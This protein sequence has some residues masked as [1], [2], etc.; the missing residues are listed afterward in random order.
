MFQDNQRDDMTRLKLAICIPVYDKPEAMFMQS[1]LAAIR[2][3]PQANLTN[4]HDEKYHADVQTF[5][6][7]SSNL[8]QNRH[9]LAAEAV[10][11]GADYMLFADADH[12]FPED[13]IARLW[14]R[15]KQ[16]I[17]CNY[18]RRCTPTA[19]TAAQDVTSADEEDYKN[20]VYTSPEKAD[21]GLVEEVLHLGFGLSLIRMDVFDALQ[22]HAEAQGKSSFLPLFKFE[23][24][25]TGANAIGEDVYFFQKCRAAGLKVWVDHH[26]SW[27]VGHIAA[28]IMTNAHAWRQK[29]KWAEQC[30]AA[31]K[32]YEERAKE[33]EGA[34]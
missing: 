4:D 29:D 5:I 1:L 3:F 15:N 31:F 26:L 28:A 19:P 27:E 9:K 8:C 2:H 33:L 22:D 17:G 6:V 7:T 12:V 11:W 24:D 13:A 10:N 23:D 30:Q 14:S 18:A 21:A 25:G 32:K 16:I 34:D 20:L